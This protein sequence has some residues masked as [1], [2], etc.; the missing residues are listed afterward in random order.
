VIPAATQAPRAV[1]SQLAA[2][3]NGVLDGG[4][5]IRIEGVTHD[6]RAVRPGWL[7]VAVPGERWDGREFIAEAAEAG[8]AAIASQHPR[9]EGEAAGL[10]WLRVEDA[11]AALADLAY[12]FWGHPDRRMALVGV[13]GTN[14]KTSTAWLLE[15]ILA[16]AGRRAAL[17]GTLLNRYGGAEEVASYTTPEAPVLAR[18]LHTAAEAGA[19]GAVMEVS[20]HGLAQHRV[21]GLEFRAALFTN[22][23]REHL[24]FH[25]DMESYFQAKARLF[26]EGLGPDGTAVCNADDPRGERM[27]DLCA[28]RVV[29]FGRVSSADLRIARMEPGLAGLEIDLE[30]LASLSLTSRMVGEVNAYNIAAA[31]AAALALGVEPGAVARAVAGFDGVPGRMQSVSEGQPFAVVVDYAHTG[32]AMEALLRGV[33]GMGAGRVITVFGCGGDRDA[34]KRAVLGETA[35]RHSDLVVLTDDNPRGED[36]EAILEQVLEGARRVEGREVRVERDRGKALRLAVSLARPGDAVVAAGK[37]AERYQQYGD[38]KLPWSD[39]ETLQTALREAR[40]EEA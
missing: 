7:Y 27:A 28:G 31:A 32:E 24:D 25:G 29:R 1:L 22:L 20:S 14:G 2:S 9:R 8:A 37:G 16:E 11:R 10:P 26:T 23:D 15:A 13:T 17:L 6:S 3:C 33:R 36:P 38:D 34:S 39:V 12:E 21:R 35:A 40:E 30:G 19:W 18:W 4:A 5:A